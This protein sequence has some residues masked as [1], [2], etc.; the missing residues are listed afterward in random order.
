MNHDLY[1]KD[2]IPVLNV[3]DV[4]AFAEVGVTLE[5]IKLGP[6]GHPGDDAVTGIAIKD[7]HALSRDELRGGSGRDRV[8]FNSPSRI[9]PR[10][11]EG[12]RYP[13]AA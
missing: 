11:V 13:S 8:K 3:L 5:T 12:H 9:F 4:N 2:R 10:T 7:L 1:L 6:V